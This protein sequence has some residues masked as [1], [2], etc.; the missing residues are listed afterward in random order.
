M[1]RNSPPRLDALPFDVVHVLFEHL[2]PD[3]RIMLT[4]TFSFFR[5]YWRPQAWKQVVVCAR[6]VQLF[7]RR[8]EL[9]VRTVSLDHGSDLALHVSE[10]YAYPLVMNPLAQSCCF[11]MLWIMDPPRVW[12]GTVD[13][14]RE[15]ERSP[16]GAA[17]SVSCAQSYT[18]RSSNVREDTTEP[19]PGV[20]V[21]SSMDA[22]SPLLSM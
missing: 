3:S 21:S 1:G 6:T 17:T 11:R 15:Q 7:T 13:L 2:E 10:I 16:L 5:N 9:F 14:G 8:A 12:E 4:G 18:I 22:S 19:D 20:S